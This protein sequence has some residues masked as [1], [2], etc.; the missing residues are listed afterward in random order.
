MYPPTT[1][2]I[3][4]CPSIQLANMLTNEE[5]ARAWICHVVSG[6][7]EVYPK[8]IQTQLQGCLAGIPVASVSLFLFEIK[9]HFTLYAPFSYFLL[10]T[11]SACSILRLR[12]LK[13]R[14][15]KKRI[16]LLVM[17]VALLALSWK[18]ILTFL[19]GNMK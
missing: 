15:R 19:H 18:P 3:P 8:F 9:L 17:L 7:P 5:I 13:K 16:P 12:L 10:M 6:I 2:L 4:P 1:I 14:R 11:M